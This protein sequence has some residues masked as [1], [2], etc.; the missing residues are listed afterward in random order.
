MS[1][2]L[3]IPHDG[4]KLQLVYCRTC[5]EQ[6]SADSKICPSCGEENVAGNTQSH[7]LGTVPNKTPR[8]PLALLAAAFIIFLL[9][10]YGPFRSDSTHAASERLIAQTKAIVNTTAAAIASAKSP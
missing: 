4:L 2:A 3:S 7:P 5:G 8:W 9:Y 10:M 6:Y 1:V